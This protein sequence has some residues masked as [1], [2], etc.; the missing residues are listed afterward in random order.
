[1]HDLQAQ[2][3]AGGARTGPYARD[4]LVQIPTIYQSLDVLELPSRSR[5]NWTEQFG[6]VLIEAMDA[7][8]RGRL[9]TAK[10]R[11]SIGTPGLFSRKTTFRRSSSPRAPDG[12]TRRCAPS[13]HSG[14]RAVFG[15]VYPAQ[16]CARDLYG[17]S[18]SCTHEHAHAS[19]ERT[20]RWLNS[21][22]CACFYLWATLTA[23]TEMHRA[24]HG[25]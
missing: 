5:P 1:V 16:H 17:P 3:K 23:I 6:R 8:I 11:T 7:G 14:P 9:T 15:A 21:S 18:G 12:G 2:I 25:I 19:C 13:G 4:P 20:A 24:T 10:S 22:V